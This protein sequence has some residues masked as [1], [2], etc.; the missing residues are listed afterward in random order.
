MT[1]QIHDS[2][3][4]RQIY[5]PII[6]V[7]DNTFIGNERSRGKKLGKVK[8]LTRLDFF[9]VSLCNLLENR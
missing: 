7:K 4:A 3:D 6:T 9:N 2:W 1:Y 5:G 8:K